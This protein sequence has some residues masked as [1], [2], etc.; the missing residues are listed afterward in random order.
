[1]G[2]LSMEKLF[3][4]KQ[5]LEKCTVQKKLPEL[6]ELRK[7]LR[8]VLK[9]VDYEIEQHDPKPRDPHKIC[10]ECQSDSVRKHGRAPSL[11]LYCM[12]CS[13]AYSVNRQPLYYRKRHHDKILDLIVQIHTTNKSAT[14]IIEHLE[15]SSKTYYKWRREILLVFPQLASKFKNRRKK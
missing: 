6:R 15:I 5:L 12:D 3:Y 2:K 13:K 8:D 7:F 11:R 9:Q 1:M 14:E 4:I 10:P